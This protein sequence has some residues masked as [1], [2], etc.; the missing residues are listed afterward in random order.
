MRQHFG[1][2]DGDDLITG[3]F[4]CHLVRK[5]VHHGHLCTR[6][7]LRVKAGPLEHIAGQ[8]QDRDND[9]GDSV[10]SR[11]SSLPW[12]TYRPTS[13]HPSYS[14]YSLLILLS[15]LICTKNIFLNSEILLLQIREEQG[16]K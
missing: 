14:G 12:A 3:I 5:D 8:R 10:T 13:T 15:Y 4:G 11:A 16:E 7:D 6:Q 1:D 9:G 2:L